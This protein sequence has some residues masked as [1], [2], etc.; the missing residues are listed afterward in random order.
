M[1]NITVRNAD[2]EVPWD[3]NIDYAVQVA[4]GNAVMRSKV[5]QY[6][7]RRSTCSGIPHVKV[8][9][10]GNLHYDWDVVRVIVGRRG[11]D[12]LLL[13][14]MVTNDR[15]A[16]VGTDYL[17]VVRALGSKGYGGYPIPK[18]ARIS[19]QDDGFN[20]HGYTDDEWLNE[21]DEALVS[22]R[23]EAIMRQMIR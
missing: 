6:D 17:L 10:D 20:H 11:V 8:T 14:R 7:L 9:L 3:D 16:N 12:E 13:A 2:I 5:D 21:W 15:G 19:R 18:V 22:L 1:A 4:L 23:E